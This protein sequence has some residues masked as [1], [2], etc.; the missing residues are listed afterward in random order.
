MTPDVN[1]LIAASRSDH[2]HH[3][4]ALAWLNTGLDTAETAGQ[5]LLILPL[6]ASG[7]LRL[8]THPKVFTQPMPY[9]AAQTFIR[10][11][12]NSPGV[13]MPTLGKEW[14]LFEMLCEQ[15][16][17]VGNDIPDAWIAAAVLGNHDHLV[18]FDKGFLRFLTPDQFTL[19]RP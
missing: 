15:H 17:L 16:G 14:A 5:P 9:L 12:L 10:T 6:V 8:S 7:F 11:V 3:T 13:V 4:Q 2:P 19:L 18:S 1:I